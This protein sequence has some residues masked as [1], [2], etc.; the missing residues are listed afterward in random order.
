MSKV[1][2]RDLFSVLK[3]E[4]HLR[5]G[6]VEILITLKVSANPRHQHGLAQMTLDPIWR[7]QGWIDKPYVKLAHDLTLPNGK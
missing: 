4:K 5:R 7:H 6:L 2:F 3:Y 1:W